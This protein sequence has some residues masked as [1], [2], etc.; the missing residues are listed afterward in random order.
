[1]TPTFTASPTPTF[2]GS[3]TPSY[4]ASPTP[5]DTPA[6]PRSALGHD[7]LAPNPVSA[8]RPV[9]LQMAAQPRAT[10]WNVY[11]LDQRLVATLDFGVQT[12]Q[13]WDTQGAA[14]GLYFIQVEVDEAGGGRH[15]G[16]FK[17]LVAP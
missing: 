10:H 9:C 11:R 14:P 3:P 7:L 4:T 8:G 5:T 16:R 13:C 1:P 6:W 15:S 2:S 12:Q 17:V